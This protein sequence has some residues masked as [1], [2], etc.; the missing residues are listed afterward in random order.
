[1]RLVRGTLTS[2]KKVSLIR[3]SAQVRSG[4]TSIPLVSIGTM[5]TDS[6]LCLAAVRSVR[7]NSHSWVAECAKLFQILDPLI[8]HSSPSSS[9]WVRRLAR[10]VPALGSEYPMAAKISPRAMPGRNSA[11]FCSVP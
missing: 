8:T 2:V 3:Q 11:L 6:P 4:R 1:M 9:A 7:T 10:S 5:M